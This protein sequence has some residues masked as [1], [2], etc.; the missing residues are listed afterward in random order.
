MTILAATDFSPCS[1]TA[2]RLAATMARRRQTALTLLHTVEPVPVDAMAAPL[3]GSWEAEL[4]K[5]A[6]ESLEA[7]ASEFRKSGLV[8]HVQVQI[9]S[10]VR[11]ILDSAA[12][13]RPE[14]IVIGTH[15]RRGVC[16]LASRQLR[17]GGGARLDLPG[18]RHGRGLGRDSIAGTGALH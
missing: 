18:P 11:S 1:L 14:L 7:Q 2:V 5:T 12:T 17:R 15:G 6:E 16:A 13:S 9:G 3:I 8:V 4:A 10:A